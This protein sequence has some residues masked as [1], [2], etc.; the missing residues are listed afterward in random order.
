MLLYVNSML[1]NNESYN[2]L[3]WIMALMWF[4]LVIIVD[5]TIVTILEAILEQV[6]ET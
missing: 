5:F 2:A 4:A 1:S 6:C 3:S